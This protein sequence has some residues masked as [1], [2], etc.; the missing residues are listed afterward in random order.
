MIRS[1]RSAVAAVAA[2]CFLLAP[3]ATRAADPVPARP[4]HPAPAAPGADQAPS[5]IP[6]KTVVE[7]RVVLPMDL[8]K[9]Q[10]I[11]DVK[12]NGKGP[13][14]MFLDTGAGTMV[15]DDDLAKELG[16]DTI[17]ST[18]LGDPRDPQAIRA[19]VVELDRVELGAARFEKVRA[20]AWDRSTLRR[21]GAEVPRGVVGIGVFHD[22]LLTL[23][24]PKA[25]VRLA[26]G[27]LPESDGERV[28]DYRS[29]MG[30][31]VIP[32][33]LGTR[34]YQAHLDSGSPAGF[35]LPL[36]EKDSLTVLGALKEVGRGRS[37]NSTM[38]IHAAQLADTMRIGSHVFPQPEVQFNDALPDA[39]VGGRLL[40]EFI[41]ILD[42]PNR[43]VRLERTGRA[44][45]A[46]ALPAPPM[47]APTPTPDR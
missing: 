3:A 24:Y 34:T 21:G 41:V 10:P 16:L 13:F 9:G 12:L 35:M 25:Q 40:R 17:D 7:G 6:G 11:V 18:R 20:V 31:P 43:R 2:V 39:N 29:P 8:A 26:T 33:R 28:L 38:T 47:P 15:L 44:V 45:T 46:P 1:F 14:R 36:V 42:Q 32:V 37:A 27:M 23:D 4:S 30:I 19:D 22:V 5:S